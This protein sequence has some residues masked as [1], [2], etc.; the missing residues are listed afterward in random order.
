ME[1]RTS[2]LPTSAFDQVLPVTNPST[3]AV[4]A[5][6]G[7]SDSEHVDLAL[8]TAFDCYHNIGLRLSLGQRVAVLERLVELMSA[9][10]DRLANTIA[11][12]GGKPLADAIVEACRAIQG[13]KKCIE[14]ISVDAG[15]VVPMGMYGNSANRL[16]FTQKEPIGVVLAISAFNHPLNLIVHQVGA[17]IAAGCPCIVKPAP[18]TPLSCLNFYDLLLEAGLPKA[19]LQVIITDSIELASRLVKSDK[20]QFL[21]FIGSARVGWQ[22]RTQ[23]QPGVR[24]ALEHGGAAPLVVTAN[25]DL[26]KAAQAITKG[27]FYH[28]GQVC[29]STQRVFVEEAVADKLTTLLK[30]SVSRLVVGD[31]GNRD[32]EVGPLIREQ[33][34]VRVDQWVREAIDNGAELICG[35]QATNGRFYQPT[36]LLNPSINDKVS[37]EE[38]FGPVVCLFT[39]KN[40]ETALQQAN[41]LGFAFQAAVFSQ[42]LDECLA[43]YKQLQASTVMIN[44]HSAFREDGMPFA[45]LKQSG[46]AVGGIHHTIHDM[47][48][49]KL[50]VVHSEALS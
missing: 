15:S 26:E 2:H 48:I 40:I 50:M 6:V 12:E 10:Q 4:I 30:A 29:V 21:S 25:A 49:D 31:A 5:T 17:A 7:S 39:Y 47:Q 3:G 32:T 37:C 24:C 45:G 9:Q 23:V 11:Q 1:Q 46:L 41:S 36:L 19:Y 34:V 43:I 14:A 35:G 28:A 22:L 42:H 13:V 16:A 20:I 8:N 38:I 44:D 18:D 33:E 27:G